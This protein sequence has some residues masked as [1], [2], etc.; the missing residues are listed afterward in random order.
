MI[1]LWVSVKMMH[2]N[3][4]SALLLTLL[5]HQTPADC[6][7][8]FQLNSLYPAFLLSHKLSQTNFLK[9]SLKALRSL[10]CYIYSVIYIVLQIYNTHSGLAGKWLGKVSF[11]LPF[12]SRLWPS[13]WDISFLSLTFCLFFPVCIVTQ[14]H[15]SFT[16][17]TL[18]VPSL[19]KSSPLTPF[20]SS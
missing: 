15:S 17:L 7:I 19:L 13:I 6:H 9:V 3:K 18:P 11:S 16:G 5:K 20:L 4:N 10:P 1:T 8:F 12:L 2:L 14:A